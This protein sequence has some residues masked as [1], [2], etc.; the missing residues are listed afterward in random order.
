[1]GQD[2]REFIINN[3]MSPGFMVHEAQDII[4]VE[5]EET[6]KSELKVHLSSKDNLS[7]ANVDKK[8]TEMQFFQKEA[9]KS[10]FKRVDHI[11]FSHQYA[12]QW[13]LY[14][15]E[16]KGSVGDKKWVEIKGKFRASYLLAQAIA[17]MLDLDIVETVMYTTFEKVQ[18]EKSDTMP[19]ARRGRVGGKYIRM[20]KE[21]EGESFGLNLGE[22]I[23]FVHR[24][25]QMVRYTDGILKGDLTEQTPSL[26]NDL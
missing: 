19:T 13:K 12:D 2:K 10:M 1:M 26:A 8:K 18:F 5:T 21:W 24:P 9:S 16:M 6:G 22:R 20:E 3:L 17:G 4:L 14:L 7:I 23:S 25:V 11:I 15:I